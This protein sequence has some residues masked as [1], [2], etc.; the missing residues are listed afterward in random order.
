[1]RFL[2]YTITSCCGIRP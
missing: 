2:N 1:M